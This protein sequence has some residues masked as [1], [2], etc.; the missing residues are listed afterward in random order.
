MRR[1]HEPWTPQDGERLRAFAAQGASVVKAAAALRRKTMSI[2]NRALALGCRFPPLRIARQKWADPSD[3]EAGL[4]TDR[5]PGRSIKSARNHEACVAWWQELK[6]VARVVGRQN[7]SRYI[8]SAYWFFVAGEP[9]AKARV[10][11]I[12]CE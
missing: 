2:R 6:V 5:R 10:R 9:T 7:R 1:I 12:V 11:A 4:L 8:R 3:S